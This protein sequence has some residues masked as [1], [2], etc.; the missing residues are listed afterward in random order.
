M[1][2]DVD[3]SVFFDATEHGEL[4]TINGV[5]GI[6]VLFANP[7]LIEQ[8]I[9]GNVPTLL[10]TEVDVP[11]G[12]VEGSPVVVRGRVYKVAA[13]APGGLGAVAIKLEYVSG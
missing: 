13:L 10:C 4:A 6:T 11:T 3:F 7:D 8:D 12:T 2:L 9:D 5:A 1:P